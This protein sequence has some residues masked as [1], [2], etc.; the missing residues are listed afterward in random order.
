MQSQNEERRRGFF[1]SA[2]VRVHGRACV[3][4]SLWLWSVIKA[5]LGYQ[6]SS[7]FT[8]WLDYCNLVNFTPPALP[9]STF[10]GHKE[11]PHHWATGE[12]DQ[13]S[14]AQ[15]LLSLWNLHFLWIKALM[16][17]PQGPIRIQQCTSI[18]CTGDLTHTSKVIYL[19]QLHWF[20]YLHPP[21]L[22]STC[23]YWHPTA[24]RTHSSS[25]LCL[26][27]DSIHLAPHSH[28]K[29][30]FNPKTVQGNCATSET[31]FSRMRILVF[32]M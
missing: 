6:I 17:I 29:S 4:V 5:A 24:S 32:N 3:C 8:P 1:S 16:A 9:F 30:C 27:G 18:H 25:H 15:Q 23:I 20:L 11:P 7:G 28:P 12:S 13:C 26:C 19:H 10:P 31:H 22:V 2:C 21:T 14:D